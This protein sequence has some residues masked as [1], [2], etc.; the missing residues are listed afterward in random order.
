MVKLLNQMTL[1]CKYSCK[2]TSINQKLSF[3]QLR[4][5]IQIENVLRNVLKQITSR[6][7]LNVLKFNYPH[8]SKNSF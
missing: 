1:K 2:N 7:P 6:K 5:P 8:F 3:L 4:H